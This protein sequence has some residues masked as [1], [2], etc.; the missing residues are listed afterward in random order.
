MW[1]QRERERKKRGFWCV[2]KDAH[3]AGTSSA[4][5]EGMGAAQGAAGRRPEQLLAGGGGDR[6]RGGAAGRGRAGR[7]RNIL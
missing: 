4:E 2:G 6:L 3:R 7:V 5:A 1:V